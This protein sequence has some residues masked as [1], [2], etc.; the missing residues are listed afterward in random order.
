MVGSVKY[1]GEVRGPFTTSIIS[2]LWFL[3]FDLENV[4]FS[5]VN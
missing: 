4:Y 3:N 1:K 5:T 2:R